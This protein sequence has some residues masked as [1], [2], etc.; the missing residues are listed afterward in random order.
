MYL[1]TAQERGT[2]A[3]QAA[4]ADV[5]ASGFGGHLGRCGCKRHHAAGLREDRYTLRFATWCTGAGAPD[6][7]GEGPQGTLRGHGMLSVYQYSRHY[8]VNNTLRCGA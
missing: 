8:V 3:G 4:A 2:A 7:A 5:A 6:A 1:Q